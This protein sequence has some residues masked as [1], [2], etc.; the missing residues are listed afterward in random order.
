MTE[1]E[2]EGQVLASLLAD[3]DRAL[4]GTAHR[5][6]S[7]VAPPRVGD[8]LDRAVRGFEY[9]ARAVRKMLAV[10]A[11]ADP[12]VAQMPKI[13]REA[14]DDYQA[15]GTA[16][17]TWW[18]TCLSHRIEELERGDQVDREVEKEL[19]RGAG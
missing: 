4:G 18:S 17:S 6:V 5:T 12:F 7:Q 15:F 19:G 3:L 16:L 1:V 14:M 11:A 13:I 10:D 9:G 2:Q 8:A